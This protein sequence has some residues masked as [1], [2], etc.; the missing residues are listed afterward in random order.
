MVVDSK[1]IRPA[2]VHLLLGNAQKAKQELGWQPKLNFEGL[3]KL[4]V[5]SDLQL[6]A[7]LLEQ[8]ERHLISGVSH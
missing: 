3:V 1:Y 8:K 7:Q 4:M 5:D 6:V 2:E